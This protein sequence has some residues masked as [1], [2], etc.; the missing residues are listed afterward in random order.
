[1]GSPNCEDKYYYFITDLARQSKDN[2]W[3]Y[4][5]FRRENSSWYYLLVVILPELDTGQ[6]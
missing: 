1:M 3:K 5:M 4:S 2:Y 6:Q